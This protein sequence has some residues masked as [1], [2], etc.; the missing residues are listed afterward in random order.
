LGNYV[1]NSNVSGLV[2]GIGRDPRARPVTEQVSGVIERVT[3][4]TDG[5]QSCIVREKT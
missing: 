2:D 1:G 3:F 5:R 4:D